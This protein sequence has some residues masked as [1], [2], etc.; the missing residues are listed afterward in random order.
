MTTQLPPYCN[1][2]IDNSGEYYSEKQKKYI[3]DLSDN[4]KQ[5]N[6]FFLGLGFNIFFFI[7][8]IGFGLV[9]YN[10]NKKIQ[11]KNNQE[12]E[13]NED[14]I[15]NI[16]L[17][18]PGVV[19][20]LVIGILCFISIFFTGYKSY[21]LNKDIEKPI[22][23]DNIRPCYS[24]ITKQYVQPQQPQQSNQNTTN[25]SS[26]G[27]DLSLNSSVATGADLSSLNNTVSDQMM[28]SN[29]VFTGSG[30][31]QL[32]G[33]EISFGNSQNTNNNNTNTQNLLSDT[34]GVGNLSLDTNQNFSKTANA[35]S[36]STGNQGPVTT[37]SNGAPIVTGNSNNTP[38]GSSTTATR[39]N[40]SSTA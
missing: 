2:N 21:L 40:T 17:W 3:K 23:N 22:I 12:N 30:L 7:L 27:V 11:N 28:N 26:P 31:D 1:I 19:I 15:Q 8:F 24:N 25:R 39:L 10:S 33:L 13:E 6:L 37:T 5:K 32:K 34:T 36:T 14:I 16:S 29:T 9:L 20:S 4:K 35:T 38:S 18:T